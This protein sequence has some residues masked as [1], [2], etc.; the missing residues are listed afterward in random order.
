ME[1]LMA[2]FRAHFQNTVHSLQFT[3]DTDSICIIQNVT[4]SNWV[5]L[6]QCAIL[7]LKYT[8]LPYYIFLYNSVSVKGNLY[9]LF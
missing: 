3:K 4:L 1:A 2:H 5:V 8:I 9:T 7:I 6:Y